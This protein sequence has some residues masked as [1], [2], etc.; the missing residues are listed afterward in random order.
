MSVRDSDFESWFR[1]SPFDFGRFGGGVG[2][3]VKE[4]DEMKR[5]IGRVFEEQ[6]GDIESKAPSEL[7]R[8]YESPT[9][10]K[11]R[12]IGPLVYGYSVTIG[13]D[14]KPKIKEFGN[15]KPSPR[16]L[17]EQS[18]TREPLVDYVYNEKEGTVTV[19]A[20]MPGVSKEDIKVNVS[21][22][23]VT[24][25]AENGPKKYHADVPVEQKLDEKSTKATYANGILEL[26]IKTKGAGKAKGTEVKVE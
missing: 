1:R 11:V 9:G 21:E 16:S 22:D 8:E 2:N 24:I 18:G 15:I 17:M 7:V 12:E 10:A 20:E 19:T 26:R 23:N 3:I 6:F 4:F 13:P 25:H 14:G 5:E